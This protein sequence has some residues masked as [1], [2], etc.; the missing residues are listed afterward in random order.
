MHHDQLDGTGEYSHWQLDSFFKSSSLGRDSVSGVV[1]NC[2]D[3]STIYDVSGFTLAAFTPEY[4]C[5][6]YF[7]CYVNDTN[8]TGLSC[9]TTAYVRNGATTILSSDVTNP[10]GSGAVVP[11][12]GSYDLT[13]GTT[14]TFKVSIQSSQVGNHTTNGFLTAFVLPR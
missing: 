14:Y 12:C 2:A 5:T 9:T 8:N 6:A 3:V 7:L 4:D 1:T 13:K 11:L 10:D